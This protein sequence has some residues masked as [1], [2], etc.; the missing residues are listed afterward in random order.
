MHRSCD[1]GG[2]NTAG[3]DKALKVRPLSLFVMLGLALSNLP[4]GGYALDQKAGLANA[5]LKR[6]IASTGDRVLGATFGNT[7]SY[8]LAVPST[9]ESVGIAP[10][11]DDPKAA[12]LVNGVPVAGDQGSVALPLKEGL[13]FADILVTAQDGHTHLHYELKVNR[14]YSMPNW[15]R[16]I[17][18]G[19]FVARDSAGELVF[20]DRMWLFGGYIPELISDVWSSS[21]GVNWEHTGD[22]PDASGINVPVAVVFDGKMW[23]ATQAGAFYSSPDGRIWTRVLDRVPWGSGVGAVMNGRMWVI[24][25]SDGRQVWSSTNGVDWEMVQP[26]APWSK[27]ANYGNVLSYSGKLWLFGGTLGFYQPFKAYQDVWC[28]GDGV[29]WQR[30]TDEAPWPARRWTCTA[31]YRNRMWLIGG[32]RAQPTWQNFDDAWYSSDG[33]NWKQLVTEDVWSQ[34]HEL[35]AYVH[36]ERLWVVAGNSWPLV[37]DVWN[38]HIPGMTFTT[39]PVLEEYAGAAYRYHARADFNDSLGPISYRLKESPEWLS[40]E[41]STGVVTGTP[42]SVGDFRV[43]IEAYDEAGE[44]ISQPYTLHVVA[45]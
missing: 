12:V 13:N 41:S 15:T 43:V 4:I 38:V 27:R 45:L 18:H 37:N 9:H 20:N 30:V 1:C 22:I 11:P 3:G 14:A 6:V 25:G 5:G 10:I 31:V 26:S 29:H 34:R 42:P 16:M 28:S 23:V 2:R 21:D 40:I 8:S 44:Q 36:N 19:Q 35:S 17:E 32:F 39:Q 7:T 33:K 24:G